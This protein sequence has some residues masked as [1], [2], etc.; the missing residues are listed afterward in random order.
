MNK[1]KLTKDDLTFSE[2][3]I[4]VA[5]LMRIL[6]EVKYLVE[7]TIQEIQDIEDISMLFSSG[8]TDS[9]NIP[10]SKPT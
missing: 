10:T 2:Y 9:F 6:E 4:I 7:N 5:E 8:L 1:N 3:E